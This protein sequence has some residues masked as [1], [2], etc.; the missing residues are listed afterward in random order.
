MIT[1]ENKKLADLISNKD[2]LV[3]EGRKITR[4]IESLESKIR[5]FEN[6]E[7]LITG[8]IKVSKDLE[9]RGNALTEE[10][11]KKVEELNKIG[12]EVEQQKLDAIP[13]EIKDAHMDL[14][15]KKEVLERDRNKIALKIQ[16]IK[17]KVVPMIKKSVKPLLAEYDD[18][19]TAKAKGDN[20]EIVTFNHLEEF[21]KKFNR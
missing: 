10:I 8:R 12:R 16:K 17:D 9:E 5:S 20:V 2:L 14:L 3:N 6:K 15:K 1:L 4:D 7:K 11:N 21:K 13:K 18:I 19:E